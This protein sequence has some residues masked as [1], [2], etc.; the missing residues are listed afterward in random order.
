MKRILLFFL[1][2]AAF[3]CLIGC[4]ENFSS[5]STTKLENDGTSIPLQTTQITSSVAETS[6]VPEE[7]TPPYP[8]PQLQ[9]KKEAD[10]TNLVNAQALSDEELASFLE[11]NYSPLFHWT[12]ECRNDLNRILAYIDKVVPSYPK[13]TADTPGLEKGIFTVSLNS[14][15]FEPEAPY[16]CVTINNIRY[17]FHASDLKEEY[18]P[19]ENESDI[20]LQIGP[21]SV[22]LAEGTYGVAKEYWGEY[23]TDTHL[24]KVRVILLDETASI[25]TAEFFDFEL[26]SANDQ[27]E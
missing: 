14:Y 9:F 6:L 22:K 3:V 20:V 2:I 12:Y 15:T 8:M 11:E 17:W 18:K 16:Y 24:V 21:H 26:F 27:T 1:L 10:Y 4:Q 19:S 25:D 5:S 13:V 23:V 7:T